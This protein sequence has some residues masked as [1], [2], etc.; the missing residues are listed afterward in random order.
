MPSDPPPLPEG[1]VPEPIYVERGGKLYKTV[2]GLQS[3]PK[4]NWIARHKGLAVLLVIFLGW[5]AIFMITNWQ[6][7][8][9]Q[10]RVAKEASEKQAQVDATEKKRENVARQKMPETY[11]EAVSLAKV[12]K[13]AE[14]LPL[15]EEL[16]DS[17]QTTETCPHG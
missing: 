13:Y 14:A 5:V 4:R 12:G 8:K 3:A 15:F 9:E 10:E 11:Q 7:E 6:M 2:P 1:T 17:I 16:V